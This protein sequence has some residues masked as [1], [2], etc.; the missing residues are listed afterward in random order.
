MLFRRRGLYD[1][2]SRLV[3]SSVQG[4]FSGPSQVKWACH[5]RSESPT[6][7]SAPFTKLPG[8]GHTTRRVV[9]LLLMKWSGFVETVVEGDI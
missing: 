1:E 3:F 4:L 9:F 8:Q 6:P 7:T 5:T 2:L